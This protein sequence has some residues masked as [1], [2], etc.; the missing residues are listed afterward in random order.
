[1][2]DSIIIL[3]VDWRYTDSL[4]NAVAIQ[5]NKMFLSMKDLIIYEMQG[6]IGDIS[7]I[8]NDYINNRISKVKISALE[9][10]NSIISIDVTSLNGDDNFINAIKNLPIIY[11]EK[12]VDMGE[13]NAVYDE[14]NEFLK[15]LAN[16]VILE[17]EYDLQVVDVVELIKKISLGN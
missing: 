11:V 2:S 9:Y 13:F 8:D 6:M 14:R 12:K 7:C 4:S 5:L 1:M 16:Y 15:S 10:E 17:K 3:G